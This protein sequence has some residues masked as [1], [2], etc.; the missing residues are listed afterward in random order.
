[1]TT[2]VC[3]VDSCRKGYMKTICQGKPEKKTEYFCLENFT[4][5]SIYSWF[6]LSRN[7]KIIRKPLGIQSQEI[8][9]LWEIKRIKKSLLQV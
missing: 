6:A 4:L 7:K 1:M 5:G 2:P 3:T 9:L 8:V